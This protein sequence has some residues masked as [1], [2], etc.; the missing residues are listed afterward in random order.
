MAKK[1]TSAK[2]AAKKAARKQARARQKPP[3]PKRRGFLAIAIAAMVGLAGLI[4][5]WRPERKSEPGAT[6]ATSA[7]RLIALLENNFDYL[8]FEDGTLAAFARAY[9]KQYGPYRDSTPAEAVYGKFLLSTDFAQNGFDESRPLRF[10]ALYDP[11]ASPCFNPL[12][13]LS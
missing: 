1:K 9:E 10:L 13:D 12:A 2:A 8:R 4:A 6:P 5:F 11:Y 3:A 7:D